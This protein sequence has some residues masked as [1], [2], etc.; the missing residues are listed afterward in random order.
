[1]SAR[2]T[3]RGQ[4]CL[5]VLVRFQLPGERYVAGASFLRR[6]TPRG[7][8]AQAPSPAFGRSF[9]RLCPASPSCAAEGTSTPPRE[10]RV[11]DPAAAL[12]TLHAVSRRLI[13]EAY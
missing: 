12:L 2:E 6:K 13:P 11:G 5:G 4:I 10:A 3:K 9:S 7:S 1:M 8:G